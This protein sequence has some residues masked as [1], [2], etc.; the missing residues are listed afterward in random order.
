M[1]QLWRNNGAIARMGHMDSL[2]N[3][4][5]R[6][7]GASEE[8][9][10]LSEIIEKGA[11]SVSK[12]TLQRRLAELVRSGTLIVEGT[13]KSARYCLS[14]AREKDNHLSVEGEEIRSSVSRSPG[15]RGVVGYNRKFLEKYLPNKTFY[16]SEADR[17]QLHEMGEQPDGDEPAGTFARKILNRLLIDLS[18]NSSRLEG[19]TYS[20]LE[21]ERLL[22]EGIEAG[23]KSTLET[24]MILNHKQA[25]EFLIENAKNISLNSITIRNLHALLSD[26]LLGNT[27]ACGRIRTIRV[28]I[29][30]TVFH[31]LD[32]PQMIEECLELILEKG[33]SIQDPFEQAFFLMV[34]LP[35]LQPFEDVNKRVARLA[36][37]IPLI[38]RNL[39]P[40][41]FVDVSGDLYIEGILGVYELNRTE[42]LRDVFLWAYKR[43]TLRYSAIRHS[44][45]E[46]DPFRLRYRNEIKEL[47]NEVV[48]NGLNKE[49]AISL[50]HSFAKSKLKQEDNIRFVELVENELL[51][52]HVG[53][54]QR[55]KVTPAQFKVWKD[56]FR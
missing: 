26:G 6:V 13:T 16:L 51:T 45:Q 50:V 39:C 28:G 56:Q 20:L 24:Q 32:V 44:I 8:G 38:K 1:A 31:P 23:G 41:A 27:E 40:L 14:R 3:E 43:S 36:A 12:R 35:Y 46:P 15:L 9:L 49:E 21:T 48:I 19:N 47:V 10:T 54:I 18:W 55:Y 7:I 29:T 11:F 5:L 42:L 30:G 33:N 17:K 4:L 53:N 52:L 2:L 22:A 37:N 25:I 34:H